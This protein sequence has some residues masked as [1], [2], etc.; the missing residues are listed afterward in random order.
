MRWQNLKL[1]FVKINTNGLTLGSLG[2]SEVGSIIR[3]HVGMLVLGLFRHILRVSSVEVELQ[4]WTGNGL[5]LLGYTMTDEGSPHAVS[6][7][8]GSGS[9][10]ASLALRRAD[11]T[12]RCICQRSG[13]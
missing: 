7:R 3:D 4:P 12:V 8:S 2:H 5:R 13:K 6:V 11:A 10:S 1:G 9:C